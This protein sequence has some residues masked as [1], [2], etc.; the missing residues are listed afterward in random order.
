MGFEVEM[1]SH[2]VLKW[3]RR[4]REGRRPGKTRS[5]LGGGFVPPCGPALGAWLASSIPPGTGTFLGPMR[6]IWDRPPF[7]RN[8]QI[9]CHEALCSHRTHLLILASSASP[10]CESQVRRKNVSRLPLKLL[11]HKVPHRKILGQFGWARKRCTVVHG[12]RER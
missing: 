12:E 6:R 3:R 7:S 4:G 1:V 9:V 5:R 10:A 2:L 11:T 8:L